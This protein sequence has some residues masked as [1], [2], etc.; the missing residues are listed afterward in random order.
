MPSAVARLNLPLVQ[1][2]T[3]TDMISAVKSDNKRL[4]ALGIPSNP[5]NQSLPSAPLS[6]TMFINF[7]RVAGAKMF[8]RNDVF[9]T[10]YTAILHLAKLPAEYDMRSFNSKLPTADLRVEMSET[11]IGCSVNPHLALSEFCPE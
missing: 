3:S 1:N 10:L 11:G 8:T 5:P 6:T 4:P 2:T 7:V 9:L